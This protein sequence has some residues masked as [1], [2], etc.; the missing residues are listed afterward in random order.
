VNNE[1][2][3]LGD[4]RCADLTA[5]SETGVRCDIPSI[6][7]DLEVIRDAVHWEAGTELGSSDPT[8]LVG[9]SENKKGSPD[10]AQQSWCDISVPEQ[11]WPSWKEVQ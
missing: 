10:Q 6:V 11:I 5:G 3:E 2:D 4:D 8:V 7:V 1:V 9:K